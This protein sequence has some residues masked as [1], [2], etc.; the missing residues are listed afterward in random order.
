MTTEPQR[1]HHEVKLIAR[2]SLGFIWI[3]QGLVPK[4]LGASPLEHEIVERSGLYLRTPELTMGLI[5][6]FEIALGL[7]LV[8][9]C[10]ERWAS[11][12]TS[13]FLIVLSILVLFVEPSL[14]IGPFGGIVKNVALFVLA[15][16]VWRP[17]PEKK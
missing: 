8:S 17:T 2:L 4:L 16:I 5:G 15:W 13:V 9:G 1:P 3:Y 11:L 7:W 14:L 10:R 6:I 12:V